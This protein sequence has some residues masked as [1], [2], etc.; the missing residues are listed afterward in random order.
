MKEYTQKASTDDEIQ[1]LLACAQTNLDADRADRIRSLIREDLNWP[2]LVKTAFQHN[3]IPLFHRSLNATCPDMVPSAIQ[4]QLR[5]DLQAITFYNL[6]LTKELVTILNLLE[7]QHIRAIPYKGPILALSVYGNLALRHFGD[8]DILVCK[9]DYSQTQKFLLSQNYQ[10]V[11][12]Y[13]WESSFL[14]SQGKVCIDLHRAITPSQFPVPLDFHSLWKRCKP[15]SIGRTTTSNLSPE[16]MLII[17]TVQVAKDGMDDRC[18]LAKI[19]DIAELL[20]VAP[21]MNWDWVMEKARRLGSRRILLI[22]LHVATQLLG[23]VLPKKIILA[24]QADPAVHSLTEYIQKRLFDNT[25]K[26][27]ENFTDRAHLH[28]KFRE[29]VQ[30]KIFPYYAHFIGRHITPN[31]RDR[32]FLPLPPT[33]S[34]VYYLVRPIRIASQYAL[35]KFN[36]I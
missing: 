33:F 11:N 30:D 34:F 24:I 10:L 6:F 32:A 18:Q 12:E 2:F 15:I 20:R 13:E 25:S 16:D 31:E 36:Q 7:A 17:L 27:P 22:G 9:N 26:R 8:L 4:A 29:R 28:F 23:T 35:K 14:D 5:S 19:C 21:S 1:L 3:V